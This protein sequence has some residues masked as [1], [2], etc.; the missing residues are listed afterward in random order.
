MQDFEFRRREGIFIYFT[1]LL[2]KEMFDK[3]MEF[4]GGKSSLTSH[5]L[6]GG[7]IIGKRLTTMLYNIFFKTIYVYVCSWESHTSARM[8]RCFVG[9]LDRSDTAAS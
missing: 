8:G 9:E 5:T 4:R 2:E 7:G 3:C 6:G 1:Y